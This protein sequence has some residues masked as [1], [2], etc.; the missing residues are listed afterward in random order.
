[1][2]DLFL[3]IFPFVTSSFGSEY[4][5]NLYFLNFQC[6]RKIIDFFALSGAWCVVLVFDDRRV[7]DR[8]LGNVSL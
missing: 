7:I 3:F 8:H 5:E 2:C 1:M 4:S 6:V